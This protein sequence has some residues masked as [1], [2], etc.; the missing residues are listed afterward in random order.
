MLSIDEYNKKESEGR[1]NL[2][3]RFIRAFNPKLFIAGGFPTRV[4]YE[5]ELIRYIDS[6]HAE[7]FKIYYDNLCNGITEDELELLKK[8]TKD[9]YKITKELYNGDFLVKDPMIAAIAERRVLESTA[10]NVKDKRILEIGGGAGTLGSLLLEDNYKYS[11]TD[12]TQ[13]FYLIQNRLF[14]KISKEGI[15]EVVTD[16]LNEASKCIHIPYWKLWNMKDKPIDI[17]IAMS[18]HA[19][20]EMSPASLKF[21]LNFLRDAMKNSKDQLIVFQGG[22]WRIGQ[23]LVDLIKLF[24]DYGFNL[25]Y[26]DHSKEIAGFSLKEGSI[27]KVVLCELKQLLDS[28]VKVR[29]INALGTTIDSRLEENKVFYCSELGERMNDYF[30][31]IKKQPKV[32][33][34]RVLEFYESLGTTEESPDEEFAKY[35][36]IK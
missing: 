35:I 34:E 28:N 1:I 19:L 9:I 11:A 13:A 5:Q 21:Y 17:D 22:G 4:E 16:K 7:S 12:V 8:C 24:D 2:S 20:L 10:D 23:N 26:F 15:N 31:K 18:N 36:K 30:K 6:M 27:K 33:V 25:K 14:E 32:E 3:N 29:R